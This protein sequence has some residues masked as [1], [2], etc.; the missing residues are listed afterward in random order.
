MLRLW[1]KCFCCAL[2]AFFY[3]LN[4]SLFIRNLH[5]LKYLFIFRSRLLFHLLPC[6]VLSTQ[7]ALTIISVIGFFSAVEIAEKNDDDRWKSRMKSRKAYKKTSRTSLE[8]KNKKRSVNNRKTME[9]TILLPLFALK[10]QM[11]F[12]VMIS[13]MCVF[14]YFFSSFS[15]LLTFFLSV[16]KELPLSYRWLCAML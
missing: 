13:Y 3:Q 15:L 2:F 12:G 11:L 1:H 10:Y 5:S 9:P 7:N 8:R 16:L 6:P 14:F 4:F